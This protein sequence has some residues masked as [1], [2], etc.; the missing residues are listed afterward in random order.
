MFPGIF[1]QGMKKNYLY[2]LITSSEWLYKVDLNTRHQWYPLARL[3]GDIDAVLAEN[4]KRI[5]R[6]DAPLRVINLFPE[7]V[8]T[9]DIVRTFFLQ[10][11]PTCRRGE[12]TFV[13]AVRSTPE[14]R[15]AWARETRPDDGVDSALFRFSAVETMEHLRNFLVN[16]EEV[17]SDIRSAA[18]ARKSKELKASGAS[19]GSSKI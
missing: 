9:E 1:G 19:G 10:H 13:D 11:L 18:M 17:L 5:E 2:D 8:L 16:N 7:D 3:S 14:V 15:A 6:G 4:V 12:R